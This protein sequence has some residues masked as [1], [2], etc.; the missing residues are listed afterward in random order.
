M[1]LSGTIP[2]QSPAGQV[3]DLAKTS[4]FLHHDDFSNFGG[5]RSLLEYKQKQ[6]IIKK[7]KLGT[8]WGAQSPSI[9]GLLGGDIMKNTS[10]DSITP[11]LAGAMLDGGSSS[12]SRASEKRMYALAREQLFEEEVRA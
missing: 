9:Q 11:K 4:Q 10:G 7:M 8:T 5:K 6:E 12:Q 3:I 1:T 2:I